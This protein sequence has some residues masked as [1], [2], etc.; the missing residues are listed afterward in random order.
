M[1]DRILEFINSNDIEGLYMYLK[2]YTFVLSKVIENRSGVVEVEADGIPPTERTKEKSLKF[3]NL[4]NSPYFETFQVNE[5]KKE[6][7]IQIY[8]R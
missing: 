3:L 4:F 6:I 2:D 1:E 7:F 5:N 8:E